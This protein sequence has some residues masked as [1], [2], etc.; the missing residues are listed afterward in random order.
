MFSFSSMLTVAKKELRALFDGPAAYVVLVVFLLVWEYLFLRNVFLV[1]VASVRGLYDHLPW[2]SLVLIPAVTMG[3]L[4]QETSEGTIE[5][6]LTHPLRDAELIIGK[7]LGNVLFTAFAFAFVFPIAWSLS[8]FGPFDWGTVVAQYLASLGLA[9]TFTALGVFVSSLFKAQVP[10]LLVSATASFLLV[11]MGFEFVTQ[12]LPLELV[13]AFTQ[14][15]VLTHVNA[16][17]RGVL[18]LR[19]VLYFLGSSAAFLAL[20]WLVLASRRAG[21]SRWKQAKG[22]TWVVVFIAGV[23]ALNL[24]GRYIPG[25]LDLTA[26]KRYSLTNTTKHVLA[27]LSQPVTVTLYAS[28]K[29]PAPLQP[30]LRD[31]KDTLSDYQTLGQGHLTVEQKNPDTQ[32]S[33]AKEALDK[34]VQQ[35]QFNLVGKSE[36]QVQKGFLGIAVTA[37]SSTE[38]LPFI[39]QTD[40]LE[41]RLTSAVEKVTVTHKKR[42]RF[43]TGHDERSPD[44][45]YATLKEQLATQFD[46]DTLELASSTPSIPDTTDVLIVA[47]RKQD[48]PLLG[49][50]QRRIGTVQPCGQPHRHTGH[51]QQH[52]PAARPIPTDS[53]LGH[54]RATRS[55]PARMSTA[56]PSRGQGCTP[57]API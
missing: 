18:D 26:D 3:S 17:A 51:D 24:A 9:L 44:T 46:I 1:G 8:S 41:Y 52:R 19:D 29:L 10:A 14:L 47:G 15:S 56:P 43:L 32:D 53:G 30:V 6:L 42:L 4:A 50:Q 36:F 16:V 2:F 7:F 45:D 27:G 55:D 31:L 20:A 38:P 37:G 11:L 33:L 13:P 12:T 25:R 48:A 22:F 35:V 23:V 21:V 5:L 54:A 49:E 34:G 40:D 57:P 28:D 39:Q